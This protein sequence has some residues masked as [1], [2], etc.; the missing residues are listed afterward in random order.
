VIIAADRRVR[1][2][3]GSFID[4]K[5]TK[6]A[7]IYHRYLASFTGLAQLGPGKHTMDWFVKTASQSP[8]SIDLD[9]IADEATKAVK[10]VNTDREFKRLAFVLV[11]HNPEGA[12]TYAL[13]TNM[14]SDPKES[15]DGQRE[16]E[17]L[18]LA[19]HQFIWVA[20]NPP[21][22]STIRSVGWPMPEKA[23][24]NL[25]QRLNATHGEKQPSIDTVTHILAGA[26]EESAA[27]FISDTALIT[28]LKR[29]GEALFDVVTPGSK[30]GQ[31]V[32]VA[33]PYILFPGG[34]IMVMPS[35]RLR[36]ARHF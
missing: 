21:Q 4:D 28:I 32:D 34:A 29:D 23:N 33:S 15:P 17:V 26:I 2:R 9:G 8:N 36:K 24:N 20:D 6:T 31:T 25:I 5:F 27:D 12:I 11:G 14:H 3:D 7:V 13:I 1:T 18:P 16:V 10:K 35:Q 19:R 30:P 22:R